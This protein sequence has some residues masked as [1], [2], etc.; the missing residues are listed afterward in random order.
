VYVS[1]LELTEAHPGRREQIECKNGNYMLVTAAMY[2][3]THIFR[4]P[5]TRYVGMAGLEDLPNQPR[6]DWLIIIARTVLIN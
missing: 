6:S 4:V 5:P 2:G 1:R 3:D